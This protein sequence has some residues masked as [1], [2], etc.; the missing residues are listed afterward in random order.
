MSRT[1]AVAGASGALGRRVV[2]RL[3]DDGWR[4]RALTRDPARAPRGVEVVAGDGRDPAVAAALV[5]G[6][7]AVFSCAGASVAMARGHGWRGYRAVDT[8][9]NAALVAA[10]TAT[11]RPRFVYV[12][13]FHTPAMRRLAYVDAHERVVD[14]IVAAA[15][16]HAIVRPTGFY[17]AIVPAYL[18]L[19][20]RGAVPEIGDGRARTNP[21][22]DDDL[23][24]VCAEAIAHADPRLAIA[25]G[26]P[27]VLPRRAFVE[28]AAAALGRPAR[29][30]AVPPWLARAG[31]T[32]LRPLH[33]RV[34]Q[35]AQFLATIATTDLIAPA[36]GAARLAD[37]F[38]AAA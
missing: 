3:R 28:L 29:T 13:A 2:A 5:R 21:I 15:L 25:A 18:D 23:A 4:V 19:A 31:A 6:V 7:D 24:A 12:S 10:A 26:G 17:S 16:P 27:D 38:A 33:P 9:L 11:G 37:A 22:G 20:R 1:I 14:A 34:G 8:R 35:F 30:R 36:R 32:V